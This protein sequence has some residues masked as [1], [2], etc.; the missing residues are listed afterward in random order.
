MELNVAGLH[1]K[2]VAILETIEILNKTPGRINWHLGLK[3]ERPV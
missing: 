3:L 2:V 1:F